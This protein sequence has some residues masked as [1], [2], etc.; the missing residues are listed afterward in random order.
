M[1][2]RHTD[3]GEQKYIK[4]DSELYPNGN[5]INKGGDR[6]NYPKDYRV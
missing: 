1:E 2:R 5:G 4:S 6:S 3:K